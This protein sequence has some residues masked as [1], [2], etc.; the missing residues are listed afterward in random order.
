[1]N[2]LLKIIK[3]NKW[4]L[5]GLVIFFIGGW[6]VDVYFNNDKLSEINSNMG[7]TI[8]QT[9]GFTHADEVCRIEYVYKVNG[10]FYR[11]MSGCFKGSEN[12]KFF[13]LAYSKKNPAKAVLII[14]F[15][16]TM[17]VKMGDN[18]I[19]FKNEINDSVL[20]RWIKVEPTT[21]DESYSNFSRNQ[22]LSI[23]NCD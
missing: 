10:N 13:L 2:K 11:G 9:R 18:M 17:D 12:C 8:G 21:I 6:F 16:L 14:D 23:K 4:T 22:S 1:M 3:S 19:R 5:I 7:L 20:I 15:P